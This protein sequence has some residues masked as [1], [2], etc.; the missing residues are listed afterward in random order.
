[1]DRKKEVPFIAT[2]NSSQPRRLRLIVILGALSAFGPFSIDMY[3]PSLP[4]LSRD[5]GIGSAEAQLTLSAC[6]LGLAVGQLVVGSISDA[7]GRR[8]PLLVCLVAYAF[9]SFLCVVA[10]SILVLVILRFIQGFAGAAGIVVARAVVRDM[11]TG[12]DVARFFSLLMLVNGLA[13]I[14]APLIGGQLLHFTSWRGVFVVLMIIGM[15]IFVAVFFGLRE[16]LLPENRQ[17]GGIRTL[18]V[19]FRQLISS[20]SFIGYALSYGLAFA[21]MFSYISGSP[22]VLQGVYGISPQLFSIIFGTNALGLMLASQINGR[23]VSRIPL[24]RL[25]TIGLSA[26][27]VGGIALLLVATLG[28]GNLIG[29]LLSLFVVVASLGLILPNATTLALADHRRIAGSASALIGV[30]QFAIGAL[31]APLVGVSGTTS[32][33]PM[34]IVIAILGLSSLIAFLLLVRF[35]STSPGQK[36]RAFYSRFDTLV[37]DTDWADKRES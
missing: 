26:T 33:R 36:R 13:P 5:F 35:R 4:S 29:V 25:L 37:V 7:L 18:A 28:H 20:R 3:L 27:A 15:V 21:A 17:R 8:R 31:A 19:A 11:F 6:L 1:M 34:A 10:P 22:F 12:L 14:L 23:L 30:L 16:T 2:I 24:L 32:V 9:A